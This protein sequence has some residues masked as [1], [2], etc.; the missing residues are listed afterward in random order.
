MLSSVAPGLVAVLVVV[1]SGLLLSQMLVLLAP[2]LVELLASEVDETLVLARRRARH[3]LAPT[4]E[5][6]SLDL[7]L[8]HLSV[9]S[10][11]SS[12]FHESP[13]NSNNSYL[14]RH[15]PKDL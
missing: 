3:T 8:H 13:T 12:L 2:G 14:A 10:A 7:L 11:F 4:P 15:L 1:A 9:L 5:H 6:C